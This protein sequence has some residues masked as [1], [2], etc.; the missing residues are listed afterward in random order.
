MDEDGSKSDTDIA[1]DDK[2]SNKS[3]IRL[4]IGPN[5]LRNFIH[6]L[7]W[8]VNDFNSTIQRKHFKTL[9][10]RYRIPVDVPIRPL[11][12]FEKCYYSGVD[13]IGMYE[14]MVKAGFRLPLSAL[15]YR[16]V[17]Y[18][19]LAVTQIAPNAW[20]IFHG[21]EV[22]YGVLSKGSCRLTVE[23]FFH[24]YGPSE[25]VKSRGIYSFLPR[26]SSLRLVFETPDS[27]R[28]WKNQYFFIQGDNWVCHPNE[29]QDMP[30]VDITWGI[31]PSSGRCL[32]T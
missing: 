28:N 15:H 12:K 7:I 8:T 21:A 3:P 32:F 11:F 18:L 9:R 5:D 30:L 19:A 24:C 14:Q 6:P 10:E 26:K 2:E 31:L 29:R 23:E 1:S 16:L 25:I 22:L 13:D 4:V 17:Q 20:R 27:N